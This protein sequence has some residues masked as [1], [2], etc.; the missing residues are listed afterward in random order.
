[1]ITSQ[2]KRVFITLVAKWRPMSC[3]ALAEATAIPIEE[4]RELLLELSAKDMIKNETF[5]YYGFRCPIYALY[6]DDEQ[7]RLGASDREAAW[8]ME[9]S[10]LLEPALAA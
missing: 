3:R 7:W 4:V 6:L 9:L 8:T 2:A 1:M 5:E 10:R